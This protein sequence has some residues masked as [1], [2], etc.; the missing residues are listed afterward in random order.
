MKTTIE[1]D[2][3][4]TDSYQYMRAVAEVWSGRWWWAIVLPVISCFALGMALNP[5][6]VFVAFMIVF[7]IVPLVMMFLYFYHA[8]TPEARMA[9]LSK[10]LRISPESGIEVV[11]EPIGESESAPASTHVSW[12]EVT[13]IEYRNR[14]V[15]MHLSGS[16]YRFMLVPY[17]AMRD[18]DRQQLFYTITATTQH[19]HCGHPTKK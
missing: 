15:M 11:Y 2:V 18:S 3:H 17:D 6:F 7:L 16:R 1:T 4:R 10:R 19:S 9:I 13:D 5:A 12:D 8:L 14:D